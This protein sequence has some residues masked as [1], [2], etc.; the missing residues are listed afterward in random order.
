MYLCLL[1]E[2]LS[3]LLPFLFTPVSYIVPYRKYK[4]GSVLNFK[5]TKKERERQGRKNMDVR[6]RRGRERETSPDRAKVCM[7][8]RVKPIKKVQVVYYLSRNGQLEHPHYMEVTHL[9]NQ[10]LR[11]RGRTFNS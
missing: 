7:Q 4:G 1:S 9:A 8:P 5:P 3:F 6:S 2:A 10:H 11:L